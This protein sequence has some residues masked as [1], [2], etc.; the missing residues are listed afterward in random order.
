M[1]QIIAELTVTDVNESIAWYHELGFEVEL[2][3]LRDEDGLQ[4]VSM[5]REG[6][7]VWLLRADISRHE[8]RH[9]PGVTFYLN[10]ED[11]DRLYNH[12]VERD[13]KT[14]TRPQNQWYGLRD[15]IV[16]DPD[17]FCWAINQSIAPE[18][19]PPHPQVGQRG[20]L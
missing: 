15:F 12:L 18:E 11:V 9:A 14:E 10:V 20:L 19:T 2:E 8:S 7:S 4:W 13:I 17:G 1:Q 3:G 6:R 16:L 5:G